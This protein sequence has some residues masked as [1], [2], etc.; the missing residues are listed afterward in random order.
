[1][2]KSSN[3]STRALAYAIH[4][5]SHATANVTVNVFVLDTAQVTLNIERAIEESVTRGLIAALDKAR[6]DDQVE[7]KSRRR[8]WS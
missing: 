5:G 2:T 1:M 4:D 3:Y 8:L 6:E 7:R